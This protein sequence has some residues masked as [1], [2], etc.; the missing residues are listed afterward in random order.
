[1]NFVLQRRYLRTHEKTCRVQD[2]ITKSGPIEPP[3]TIPP[4][5][6]W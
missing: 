3:A 6:A 2:A 5:L 4:S 1:M